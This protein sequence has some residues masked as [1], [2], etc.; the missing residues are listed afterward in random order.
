MCGWDV[1]SEGPFLL[2]Q[3]FPLHFIATLVKNCGG[4]IRARWTGSLSIFSL[5]RAARKS[6]RIPAVLWRERGQVGWSKSSYNH[7]HCERES[8]SRKS[9]TSNAFQAFYLLLPNEVIGQITK[10]IPPDQLHI[11]TS[12][13]MCL[14]ALLETLERVGSNVQMAQIKK[15]SRRQNLL[16]RNETFFLTHKLRLMGSATWFAADSRVGALFNLFIW[17]SHHCV[18][19]FL[20]TTQ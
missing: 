10:V 2:F 3:P 1:S 6:L 11:G 20:V 9:I 19:V 17:P 14:I 12:A 18:P 4:S 5:F 7:R 8:S 16:Q 15:N 13:G